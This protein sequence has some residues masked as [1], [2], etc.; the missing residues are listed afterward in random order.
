MTELKVVT[1]VLRVA[2]Y[3]VCGLTGSHKLDCPRL[4]E[5]GEYDP[6]IDAAHEWSSEYHTEQGEQSND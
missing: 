5:Q 2:R 4:T 3:S 1:N 6:L